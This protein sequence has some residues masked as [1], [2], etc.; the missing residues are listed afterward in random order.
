MHES[1]SFPLWSVIPFVAMLLSIAVLPLVLPKLWHSNRNKLALSVVISVPV[2]AIL[3]LHS[4]MTLLGHSMME[5]FSFIVL[6]GA[7]F[8]ISGGVHIRGAWAGTPLV[9]TTYLAVGA[10]LANLIGTTGAS[11]LLIR[12]YLRANRKRSRRT[13]LIVFFIFI[14]SNIGGLLTPLGDPP[15]FLGF[16]RGVPFFWTLHLLP[17]WAVAVGILLVVF[18]LVDQKIFEKEDVETPGALIEDVQPKRKLQIDGKM[19][20][21]CLV[22][23]MVAAPLSAHFGWPHGVQES[24]MILMGVISYFGT[25]KEVHKANHF[26]F[27]PIAEV[28][29]L[30]LGIFVT[31]IPALE[32]LSQQSAHWKLDHAW[33][34]FWMT[35][36]LSSFLDNAPTYLTFTAL[37]SGHFGGNAQDLSL[38]LG[39]PLSEQMLRAISCGAVFMGANTYIGNGPNLMVKSIADQSGIK[40]PTFGGYLV[41][42][43]AVLVPLFLVITLIFFR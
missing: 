28:A 36:V 11:M 7:L 40:M 15:L 32:I 29:A 31:M 19:N 38:L 10:V 4:Q 27:E 26:D 13:H 5:Y 8:V 18:N 37:A 17:Q 9:N 21:L 20:F 3:A 16:L 22:G 1:A 39:N 23:V 24:I 6:L 43:G 35:G 41:Y 25:R 12:P 14:V 42:S 34:F 2:L 30:F 33:Q